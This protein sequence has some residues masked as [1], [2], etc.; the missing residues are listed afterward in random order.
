MRLVVETITANQKDGIA[1]WAMVARDLCLHHCIK[2]I[3][4]VPITQVGG[5]ELY[6]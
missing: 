1:S 4:A 6:R 2:P 3:S 5:M